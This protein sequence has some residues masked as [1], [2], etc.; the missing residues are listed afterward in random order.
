[1][2][3]YSPVYGQ[4]LEQLRIRDGQTRYELEDNIDSVR[5]L[6]GYLRILV[7]DGTIRRQGNRLGRYYIGEIPMNVVPN[8]AQI[9][10]VEGMANIQEGEEQ[11]PRGEIIVPDLVEREL[12]DYEALKFLVFVIREWKHLCEEKDAKGVSQAQGGNGIKEYLRPTDKIM[13]KENGNEEDELSES[14]KLF[15]S[16]AFH[17]QNSTQLGD[18][19]SFIDNKAV[20]K[21]I[22]GIYGLNRNNNVFLLNNNDFKTVLETEGLLPE[23]TPDDNTIYKKWKQYK[24]S[25]MYISNYVYPQNEN[26][27]TFANLY[28][29]YPSD[30]EIDDNHN[31]IENIYEEFKQAI[32]A[33]EFN[34][35]GKALTFDFLKEQ[36]IPTGHEGECISFDYPKPD[37]HLR[38]VMYCFW[39]SDGAEN[40]RAN[41]ENGGYYTEP[42]EHNDGRV[43]RDKYTFETK[44]DEF[45]AMRLCFKIL[46][47]AKEEYYI[48]F[49]ED[50]QGL[51]CYALDKTIYQLC[52][53]APFYLPE[54]REINSIGYVR[55]GKAFRKAII[56]RY[57]KTPN[58][59]KNVVIDAEHL[60]DI[61]RLLSEIL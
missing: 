41:P 49:G 21:R 48:L 54:D 14:Q 42:Y 45:R 17:V 53:R 15:R 12:E 26:P 9:D 31:E 11:M 18:A 28:E 57:Y 50:L 36:T 61:R 34:G 51:S 1:M 46:E 8:H 40:W 33:G 7:D 20:I 52:C 44:V 39:Q 24:K 22:S 29:F 5:D 4:I 19:I 3:R 10:G 58:N 38:R 6:S 25:I 16:L 30:D 43:Y 47:K 23:N 2:A 59:E 55:R 13:L 35:F 37:L 27:K 60:E 56:Y 32:S